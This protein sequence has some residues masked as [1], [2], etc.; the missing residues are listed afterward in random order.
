MYWA[1]NCSFCSGRGRLEK[2]GELVAAW[3]SC[4]SVIEETIITCVMVC[5]VFSSHVRQYFRQC[6]RN[7]PAVILGNCS[8]PHADAESQRIHQV[9]SNPK[10]IATTAWRV[11]PTRVVVHERHRHEHGKHIHL[12][13]LALTTRYIE[14]FFSYVLFHILD[15]QINLHDLEIVRLSDECNTAINFIAEGWYPSCFRAQEW[16]VTDGA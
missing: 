15:I 12:Q 11:R 7:Y 14:R 13:V 2:I 4:F 6:Q 3:K 8:L 10:P 1:V 5:A 16:L 9:P